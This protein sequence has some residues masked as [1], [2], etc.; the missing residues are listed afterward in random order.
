MEQNPQDG[1]SEHRQYLLSLGYRML[2]SMADAEDLVQET[3]LRWQQASSNEI[4]S[5][6]A[7]LTT[8]LT[9]LAL[10]HLDSARVRRE[11][12]VGPWLPEPIVTTEPTDPAEL[13]ESLTMAFL[14]LLESLSPLERVT[15]L[16]H[17]VF[18]YP[19]AEVAKIT[20]STEVA[21][22]QAFRRAKASVAER[23]PRFKPSP[24][25]AE[26]L[27]TRFLDAVQAGRLD[28]LLSMLHE[29]VV[30]YSDGGG[31]TRAALNPI[32]GPDKVARFLIGV[33][34]KGGTGLERRATFIN[35]Q[36]GF[37]GFLDGRPRTAMVLDIENDQV[38][39][40]YIVVNPQKLQNLAKEKQ[41]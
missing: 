24:S 29:N 21:C 3:F 16:L 18:D 20:G 5:P 12:Y 39:N 7:F 14:V 8:I 34:R 26:R 35:G 40:V 30:S 15:F 10:N 17:E 37:I 36:P 28:D 33:A 22:R 19:H 4:R 6:R 32:Y 13:S 23:R 41:Q 1:F 11:Q 9:R 27:T 38:R 2:G 25:A 31:L